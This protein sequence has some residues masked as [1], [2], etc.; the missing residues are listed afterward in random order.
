[1]VPYLGNESTADNLEK[2]L[3]QQEWSDSHSRRYVK[4]EWSKACANSFK[5]WPIRFSKKLANII[6]SNMAIEC[7]Y[8]VDAK[9]GSFG[10]GQN[11]FYSHNI[12]P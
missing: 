3:H 5:M 2:D 11:I 10:T 9:L 4:V 12:L 7:S 6:D 1:M 8:P